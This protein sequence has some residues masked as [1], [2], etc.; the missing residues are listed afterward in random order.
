MQSAPVAIQLW[1]GEEAPALVR[2]IVGVTN[3]FDAAPGTIRGDFA[4]T[5]GENIIHASEDDAAAEDEIARFF[6]A[7]EIVS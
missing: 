3:S 1:K 7:S 2:K 6:D 5:I 4:K